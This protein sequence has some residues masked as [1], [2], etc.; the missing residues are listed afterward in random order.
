MPEGP[1]II[2]LKEEVV[3]FSG[4]KSGVLAVTVIQNQI[5][6]PSS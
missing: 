4:K 6:S 3:Q 1:S 2:L 5:N